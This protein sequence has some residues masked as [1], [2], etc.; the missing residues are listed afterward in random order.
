MSA[1]LTEALNALAGMMWLLGYRSGERDSLKPIAEQPDLETR[2]AMRVLE[3]HGAL[4]FG[5][6]DR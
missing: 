4:D 5:G 2:E 1:D 6:V 3:K